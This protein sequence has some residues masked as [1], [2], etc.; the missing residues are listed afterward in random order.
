MR[1]QFRHDRSKAPSS[2]AKIDESTL[3][4]GKRSVAARYFFC[5]SALKHKVLFVLIS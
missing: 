5:R 4:A 2:V 3:V 1:L